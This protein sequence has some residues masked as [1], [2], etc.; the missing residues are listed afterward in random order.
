MNKQFVLALIASGALVGLGGC[1]EGDEAII[2][3]DAPTS[4][5][6]DDNSCSGNNSCNDGGNGGNGGN[7]DGGGNPVVACP[8]GTTE[9]STNVCRL[10]GSILEDM[11][12][13]AGNEYQLEGRVIVGNGNCEVSSSTACA[14]GDAVLNVTL[15][16]EAGVEV[17]G[18]PSNDPLNA[19][20]LDVNRG[21]RLMA[22]G[23]AAEPIIF[24]SAVDDNYSGSGEW[25]GIQ[26][27]GFAPHNVC[28]AAPCNVDGEGAVNFIGGDN[29]LDSSGVLQYVIITEGGT[30]ISTG[31]EINGLSLNAVGAGTTLENIQI[32]DNLDD[33]VEFYGGT[34][35]GKWIVVT[36][37]GDDSVDW[38]EGYQGNLQYVIV[39]QTAN[40]EGEAFEMD[41]EGT[42]DFLS[43]P[44]LS[45]VTVLA[46]KAAGEAEFSLNFKASSAGFFH[47]TVVTVEDS[48]ENTFTTCANIVDGAEAN[49]GTSLV[50][51]NWIQDCANG[52]GDQGQLA[53]VDMTG[54]AVN[55]NPVFASLNTLAASTAPEALLDAPLDW[56]G[57]NSAFSESVADVNFLDATDYIGA[58]DPRATT[59]WWAG[60][61][62]DGS[63]GNPEAPVVACPAGTTEVE[64]NVCR[65]PS[66]VSTDLRLIAGNEYQMQGRTIVGNGNCQLVDTNTCSSG[67]SVQNVTLTIDAGVEIKGMPSSD[68]LTA[69][70]LDVNRGSQLIARG[71]RSAPIIFSSADEGYDGSGEWGGIQL[72]GYAP[73]N[74]CA[75]V[76]CNV[77]GE[78]GVNFVG[79]EDPTDSSGVM[80]YVIITEGGTEI[81]TGDEINGLS[82]NA[83]GSGTEL[84]FIQINDNLDDG[85][86]YY[87]GTVNTKHLVVTGAGDD[88]VDWDEGFQGNLQYVL[89]KQTPNSEGEAFEMDT[90]GTL[91][92]LSK[93]TVVNGTV[94]A[95]KAAGEA[96]FSL[97]FKASS[98]GFFHNMVV[99]VAADTAATLATCAN[100][101]DGAEGN[102]NTSLVFN[103]WIQDCANGAGNGGTLSNEA[104]VGNASVVVADAA[105]DAILSSQAPEAAGITPIDW[106]VIESTFAVPNAGSGD[107]QDFDASFFDATDYMGAVNPDQTDPWWAGW[108]LSGTL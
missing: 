108:T 104:S 87:G 40:S 64:A 27:S 35:N 25:G 16:I 62:I 48:T 23:T 61:T 46:N 78:G 76:P 86:E 4:N 88:S 57:I 100:I 24:S 38:D 106:T 56:A 75:D 21:S 44:T 89:V 92:W 73:H 9:V 13:V 67:A 19:S 85:I 103:N 20:V 66:Q 80:T 65:L 11:T 49:V 7:G 105:L 5:S 10:S 68:P 60:W 12:L 8:T 31:D 15:T 42:L 84:D 17:K 95:D 18:L 45:N 70:V 28:D 79:G 22:M 26:L 58:V 47:N 91:A 82:L 39:R 34:V 3:I 37:A 81:S 97:N 59:A 6:N 107:P 50:F 41:T 29:P 1:S 43:K 90:E 52:A 14:N 32:N 101:I 54:A 72:S 63:V 55:V 30:E 74:V 102:V 71:T 94:I 53:N 69:A 77:D 93:P 98:A 36:G 33:G 2:N 99:T 51:N 96:D 83:V